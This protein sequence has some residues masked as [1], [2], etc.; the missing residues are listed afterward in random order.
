MDLLIL[1]DWEFPCDEPFMREVYA[2]RWQDAGHRVT[3]IMRPSGNDANSQETWH[4]SPV[5]VAPDHVYR[6][7]NVLGVGS[8]AGTKWL[9][10]IWDAEGGFDVVQVR[11]DLAAMPPAQQL[12]STHDIP[13]VFRHSHLK[14]ETLI[15]GYREGVDG[16]GLIDYGKGLFGRTIRDRLLADVDAVF[17]ISNAMSQYHREVRGIETPLYSVPMGADTTLLADEID[18]EPFCLRYGLPVDEYL[19]YMGSMNPLRNLEFL[20]RV[21]SIVRESK[22]EVKLALVGGRDERQRERL[23][24]QAEAHAVGDA[25]VFTG[26]VNETDLHRAIVGAALGLSPLPPN[27]VFRTNS[28]TKVLEYLNLGTPA[29]TTRTPEQVDMVESNGAGKAVDY[30][31]EAFADTI[32]AFLNDSNARRE[33]G[34][35]GR[36]YIAKNR[37]YYYL[38][39]TVLE[40]YKS[41]IGT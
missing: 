12:A 36:E 17:T 6:Y 14:A 2:K 4:G 39:K 19:I 37:S 7:R 16:Y 8:A 9:E 10:S 41:I 38:N 3:W 32:L 22:P 15:L 21:L 27:K 26:W 23:R 35:A 33:M 29:V 28:P 24:S 20:F 11:N 34:S 30:T 31:P 18:P 25:T 1:T 40:K 13:L 5:Y